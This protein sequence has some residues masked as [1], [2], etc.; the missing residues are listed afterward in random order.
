MI[1]LR[2]AAAGG[3]AQ[4]ASTPSFNAPHSTIKSEPWATPRD[5]GGGYNHGA[6]AGAQLTL[7]AHPYMGRMQ[8]VQM[9]PSSRQR[10]E[11]QTD[12][13]QGLEQRSK[14]EC[15][16]PRREQAFGEMASIWRAAGHGLS[17]SVPPAARDALMAIHRD[18]T[19]LQTHTPTDAQAA[20]HTR[21]TEGP[22]VASEPALKA[23]DQT[24]TRPTRIITK[25]EPKPASF[26]FYDTT[27]DTSKPPLY[28]TSAD[29]DEAEAAE[30]SVSTPLPVSDGSGEVESPLR[31]GAAGNGGS[32]AA[33]ATASVSMPLP[34]ASDEGPVR[35]GAAGSG[36]S[37]AAAATAMPLSHA[38][39]E[40]PVRESAAGSAG[41]EAAAGG[42]ATMAD[43]Q[44]EAALAA[45]QDA[46]E[47][48]RFAAQ[49]LQSPP[50]QAA[51]PS[52]KVSYPGKSV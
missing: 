18:L 34:H 16:K 26:R 2:P 5:S 52:S 40:G 14:T 49:A 23:A 50:P 3:P 19:P 9:L 21:P 1:M 24:V 42:V 28:S 51:G 47:A 17:F 25:S 20:A 27:Y 15:V 10:P 37:E 29:T 36:G 44:R 41:A 32:E 12:A 11:G 13:Q 7:P 35:E 46:Q 48:E 22:P 8:A 6:Q 38:S 31:E 4:Q 39:D 45:A 30:P 43:V 33:A